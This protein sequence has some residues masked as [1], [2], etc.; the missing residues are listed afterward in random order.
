M[1][2]TEEGVVVF[3]K[4]A[5]SVHINSIGYCEMNTPVALAY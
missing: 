1:S 2:G 4:D 5:L 3:L